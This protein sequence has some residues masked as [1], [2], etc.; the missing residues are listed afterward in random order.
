M[1]AFVLRIGFPLHLVMG[2]PCHKK[3]EVR[4][5]LSTNDGNRKRPLQAAAFF[6]DASSLIGLREKAL[7]DNR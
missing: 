2:E 1:V 4:M 7:N 5:V 6:V 3:M